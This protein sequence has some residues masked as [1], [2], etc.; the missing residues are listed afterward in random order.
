MDEVKQAVAELEKEFKFS[1]APDPVDELVAV[2]AFED[3]RAWRL[4]H[5]GAVA[6]IRIFNGDDLDVVCLSVFCKSATP[7]NPQTPKLDPH[8]LKLDE[9]HRL[10]APLSWRF[11]RWANAMCLTAEDRKKAEGADKPGQA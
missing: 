3:G 4:Q 2:L 1:I 6:S 11:L 9:A 8:L 5:P 10:W 7:A